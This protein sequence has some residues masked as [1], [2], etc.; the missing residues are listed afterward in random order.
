M[1][2]CSECGRKDCCGSWMEEEHYKQTKALERQLEELDKDNRVLLDSN[3][4][5]I[6]KLENLAA[7]FY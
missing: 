1:S 6:K 3:L 7:F 5:M 2:R 4:D